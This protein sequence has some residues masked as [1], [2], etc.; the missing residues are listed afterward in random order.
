MPS[1]ARFLRELERLVMYLSVLL[2]IA[3]FVR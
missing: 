2:V 3:F 1:P